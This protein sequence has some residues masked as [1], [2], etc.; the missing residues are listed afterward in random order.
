MDYI[1]GFEREFDL[2]DTSIQHSFTVH[3]RVPV[4]PHLVI[5]AI[6]NCVSFSL[7]SGILGLLELAATRLRCRSTPVGSPSDQRCHCSIVMG[8]ARQLF[9]S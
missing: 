1:P 4:G 2:T 7:G 8:L 3:E 9:G 6:A 5:V